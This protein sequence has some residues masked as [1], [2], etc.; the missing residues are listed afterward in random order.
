MFL[1]MKSVTNREARQE[2]DRLGQLAHARETVIVTRGGE[3]WIK[4][5]PASAPQRGKSTA[6][7]KARLDRI[8]PKPITGV[9][10]VLTRLRR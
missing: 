5:V 2:F 1:R 9:A 7:F 4:L 3:P 6:D 8:S 10:E